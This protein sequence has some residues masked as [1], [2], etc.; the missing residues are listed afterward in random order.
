MLPQWQ[1]KVK[2]HLLPVLICVYA[3]HAAYVDS[4]GVNLG[5][6]CFHSRGRVESMDGAD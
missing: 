6:A 5:I 2:V 3:P 4:L 1:A